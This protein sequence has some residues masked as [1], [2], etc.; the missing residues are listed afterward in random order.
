M[1]NTE[2][3]V[4]GPDEAQAVFE[5]QLDLVE[6]ASTLWGKR[7][8]IIFLTLIFGVSS[9]IYA[10]NVTPI[11]RAEILLA[12]AQQNSSGGGMFGD[13]G[14]LAGLAGIDVISDMTQE[15]IAVL[16]SRDLARTFIVDNDLIPVL[17]SDKWNEDAGEWMGDDPEDWPDDR[18]AV[19][20]FSESVRTIR[21]DSSTGLVTLAIEW[22]D[23]QLAA[24]WANSL[25]DL[26]N[27]LLRERATRLATANIDYLREQ[28]EG[29]P[30]VPLQQS[31]A[32]LLENEM[33]NLML[34]RGN[35]EFAFRVIDRA[36][37]PKQR[38]WPART[39]IVLLAMMSGSIISSV[40]VL[41]TKAMR[42]ISAMQAVR[43]TRA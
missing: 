30:L 42:N 11:Y 6:A 15:Y 43:R 7:W 39:L 36:E 23:P 27:A 32:S 9:V 4:P 5:H 10:L 3:R 37:V 25:A 21:S 40:I 14:G 18:D 29:S 31:I 26:A 20:L 8:V 16:A 28:L 13:L 41:I 12:P 17:F 34:A 35:R 24:D 2:L 33:Q 19:R 22:T 1:T 38:V